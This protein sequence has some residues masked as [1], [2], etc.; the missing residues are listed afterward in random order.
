MASLKQASRQSPEQARQIAGLS[1]SVSTTAIT[2]L[3]YP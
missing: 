3:E 1:C 2:S